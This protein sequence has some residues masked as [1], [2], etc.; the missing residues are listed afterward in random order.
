MT[1]TLPIQN[2]L[3]TCYIPGP[4]LNDRKYII[5][6]FILQ[7]RLTLRVNLDREKIR[8]RV[9]IFGSFLCLLFSASTR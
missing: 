1:F 4:V 2:I 5:P 6:D 8:S 3:R 7:L 9:L